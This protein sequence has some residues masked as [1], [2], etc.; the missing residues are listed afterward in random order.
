M[1]LKNIKK[2]SIKNNFC[3]YHNDISSS[4]MIDAKK[5]LENKQENLIVLA[6]EQTKGKGR[7]GN[8][9][10]SPRGNIYSSIAINNNLEVKDYFQ[11]SILTLI[12]VK[13]TIEDFGETSIFF[14]WPNDIFYKNMK[15]GGLILEPFLSNNRNKF[16][17][18]G[19]GI[20]INSSPKITSYP[21]TC[22]NKIIK[23]DNQ[24]V[25]FERF[26][27]NF[28][29]NLNNF[30]IKKNI[31][32]ENFK[33]SLMFLDKKIKIKIDNKKYINGIFCGVNIDGSLILKEKNKFL[34]IYSGNIIV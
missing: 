28:F 3:F 19:L 29:S 2:I 15:I 24:Y 20:N 10:V 23:I 13:K 6:E 30:F 16:V 22:I 26:L 25:F 12:S 32:F 34:N 17:I 8:F 18:I 27:L 21:T 1:N 31:F 14:K 11:Y 7:R 33:K 4:T 5:Y 9:W